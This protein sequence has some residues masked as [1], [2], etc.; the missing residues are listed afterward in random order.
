LTGLITYPIRYPIGQG[1]AGPVTELLPA[2][3]KFS[4]SNTTFPLTEAKTSKLF[5]LQIWLSTPWKAGQT[6]E[7]LIFTGWLSAQISLTMDVVPS[8]AVTV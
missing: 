6:Q 3:V 5:C 8:S 2:I 7:N 1:G 4:V